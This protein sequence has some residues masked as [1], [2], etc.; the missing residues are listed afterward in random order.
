MYLELDL[1]LIKKK[2]NII[3]A[4]FTKSNTKILLIKQLTFPSD[5]FAL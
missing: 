4:K 1:S 5:N 2:I 3:F